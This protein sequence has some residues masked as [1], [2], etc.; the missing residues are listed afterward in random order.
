MSMHYSTPPQRSHRRPSR[1]E[2][3]SPSES[4]AKSLGELIRAARLANGRPLAEL[5]PEAGL[6]ES[7]WQAI[8]AGELP[9]AWEQI[10]MLAMVLRLG[11]SWMPYL[12]K[13][14]AAAWPQ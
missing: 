14:W 4:S 5:A 2:Q 10:L 11:R 1:P 9:V 8:E 13:R 3:V 12:S 7:E 6:T